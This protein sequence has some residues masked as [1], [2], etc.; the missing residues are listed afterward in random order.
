MAYPFDTF[1][2]NRLPNGDWGKSREAYWAASATVPRTRQIR[3]NTG[4][5]K[6]IV[7]PANVRVHG[8]IVVFNNNPSVAQAAITIGT[9]AAGTQVSAGASAPANTTNILV[10]TDTGVFRTPRTLYIESAAWQKGVHLV[11]NVTE[12]PPTAD[13][14][15]KS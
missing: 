12:Y 11:L 15:A 13:T 8:E 3:I 5:N 2:A 6:Q 14:S 4:G 10:A 1:D 7:L 9:A